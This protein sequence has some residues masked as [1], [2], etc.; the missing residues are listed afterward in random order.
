MA[1]QDQKLGPP[2]ARTTPFLP[3]VL[4]LGLFSPGFC[5]QVS[6]VVEVEI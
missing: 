4:A 3:T 6:L 1:K 2:T 5:L